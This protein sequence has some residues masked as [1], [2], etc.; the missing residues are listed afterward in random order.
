[1]WTVSQ[2]VHLYQE[3][4]KVMGDDFMVQD[5]N[6]QDVKTSLL[7]SMKPYQALSPADEQARQRALAES[8]SALQVSPYTPHSSC[9]C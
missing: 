6:S 8:P 7:N 2:V 1:M 9:L 4:R 5:L 3:L